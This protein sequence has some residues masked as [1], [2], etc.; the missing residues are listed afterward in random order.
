[1]FHAPA[2]R[3]PPDSGK[4]GLTTKDLFASCFLPFAFCFSE[5]CFGDAEAD[6]IVAVIRLVVVANGA[7]PVVAGLIVPPAATER[8]IS[9]CP[10]SASL[11]NETSLTKLQ[12]FKKFSRQKPRT[13][14]LLPKGSKNQKQ[15]QCK[16]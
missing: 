4:T 2:T 11:L 15:K 5:E 16:G 3:E 6:I 13:A 9:V 8:T 10:Y 7:C 14:G 1:L 12:I